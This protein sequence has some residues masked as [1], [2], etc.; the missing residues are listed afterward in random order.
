MDHISK[1]PI[2]R[3]H[4]TSQG[5]LY[6]GVIKMF[7]AYYE[8]EA[9]KHDKKNEVTLRTLILI[10]RLIEGP[11]HQKTF[12][13]VSD[14]C[15]NHDLGALIARVLLV[16]GKFSMMAHFISPFEPKET[17]WH[18]WDDLIRQ[19][20]QPSRACLY[21]EPKQLSQHNR[22]PSR[23]QRG[24]CRPREQSLARSGFNSW[25]GPDEYAS[26]GDE[27]ARSV[28][29][30]VGHGWLQLAPLPN[31][32]AGVAWDYVLVRLQ[33]GDVLRN[34]LPSPRPRG[35]PRSAV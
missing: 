33:E 6:S 14:L 2:C 27:V 8:G 31:V 5:N 1:L 35:W 32:Q 26:R 21:I 15:Y 25:F 28:L 23:Q 34:F 20:S 24:I 10:T 16:W 17:R 7:W 29:Q 9:V 30:G 13:R 19:R 4:M 22:D 11:S 3:K 18:F 12:Q